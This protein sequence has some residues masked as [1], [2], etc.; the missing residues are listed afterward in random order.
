M[1]EV[2]SV[3]TWADSF[4]R[5]HA[6]VTFPGI[7]YGPQYLNGEIARIRAKARRAIRREIAARQGEQR[8]TVRVKVAAND[9]DHMN[10][11]RS[12]TF[13]ER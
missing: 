5:W 13:A 10:V 9:L 2:E 6:R 11:M 7:G 1:G 3:H 12:I 8:F 4:G